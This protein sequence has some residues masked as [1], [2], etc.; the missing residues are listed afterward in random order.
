MKMKRPLLILLVAFL[1]VSPVALK[2]QYSIRYQIS[3]LKSG[4]A[5]LLA[6]RGNTFDPVDSC[7]IS[8]G[9]IQFSLSDSLPTGV[10]RISFADSL[11]T[12]VIFNKENIELSNRMPQLDRINVISSRENAVFFYYWKISGIINDTINQIASTGDILWEASGHVMTHELDS[13]QRKAN[14]LNRRLDRLS[15]SLV[16]ANSNLFV[17]KIIRAYAKPDFYRYLKTAGAYPYKSPYDFLRDHYFDNIDFS[18]NR[19]LNSEVLYVS[20]TDYLNMYGDPPSTE[21]YVRAIDTLMHR[22]AKNQNMMEYA[23]KLLLNTFET[24]SWEKVYLH[25]TDVYVYPNSCEL[26]GG[27]A[28]LAT[29]EV[30]R[31]LA[32][33]KPAPPIV[34]PDI[35]GKQ[36]SL[37]DIPAK[38]T[39][40]LFWSAECSHCHEAMPA[41]MALY[42]KWHDK[43]L[44]VVA[45]SI[46]VN[47][48]EWKEAAAKTDQRWIHLC[49]LKGVD[50]PVLKAY[51][52]WKTPGFFL[53]SENKTILSKP[54]M[55][56]QISDLLPQYLK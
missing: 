23:L 45:V 36:T 15:D 2:A 42:D 19:L 35:N 31:N 11:F 54:L 50:S 5:Y 39:L 1:C 37:Y 6:V 9:L 46:D 28:F 48:K 34:M 56:D 49:D 7:S 14:F 21:N 3:G 51:H 8:N 13:M 24:S 26:E 4:K 12:D 43:G 17:S 32:P 38:V 52:T 27:D 33:G 55:V 53:L 18:D 41:I 16:R 47:E 20:I 44:Q 29:A 30:L 10:Y 25:L 40:L 22:F